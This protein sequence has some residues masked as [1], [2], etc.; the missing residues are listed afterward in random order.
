[1]VVVYYD[2]ETTGLN[3]NRDQIVSIGAVTENGDEF[4]EYV[5]PTCRIHKNAT[6]VHGIAKDHRNNRIYDVNTRYYIDAD[7]DP[8]NVLRRF[9]TWLWD[10]N[11]TFLVAHANLRFDS[12]IFENCME[13]FGLADECDADQ[14]ENVIQLVDSLEIMSGKFIFVLIQSD[15][16]LTRF[17]Y[18][19]T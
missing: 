2:L 12:I 13:K 4:E 6:K 14:G 5:V 19:L 17:I 18:L 11:A 15:Y 3:V 10:N 16:E 8:E 9:M 7:D 1:M